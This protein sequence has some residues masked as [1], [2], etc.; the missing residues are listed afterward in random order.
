LFFTPPKVSLIP[1]PLPCFQCTC[2]D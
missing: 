1:K 2:N